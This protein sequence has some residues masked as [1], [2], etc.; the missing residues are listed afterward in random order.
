MLISI[1]MEEETIRFLLECQFATPLNM[2][3]PTD[4]E[5]LYRQYESAIFLMKLFEG[6]LQVG[7]SGKGILTV[8]KI[9]IRRHTPVLVVD[10]NA[11]SLQLMERYLS[12]SSY[13]FVGLMDAQ[14]VVEKASEIRPGAIVLDV[15]MPEKDGWNLLGQ[16]RQ[17]PTTRGIPVIICTILAQHDLALALGADDFLRKPIRRQTLLECLNR[18]LASQSKDA[19]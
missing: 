5:R 13:R 9:P 7:A 11:D 8:L 16:L 1:E 12:G 3:S 14:Q 15:M 4:T 6:T 2:T 19:G 10:D 18:V 17:H